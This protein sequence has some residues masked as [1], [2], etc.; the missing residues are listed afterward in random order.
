[1][2]YSRLSPTVIQKER[3]LRQQLRGQ[4]YQPNY[5][6]ISG[7]RAP[8]LNRMLPLA[9]KRSVHQQGLAIDIWIWDVNGDGRSNRRD[10]EIC[11][12]TLDRID[13]QQKS[14]RGGLGTYYKSVGRMVHFD[15]A[16]RKRRWAE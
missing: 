7:Y 9:S 4:G 10:V 6:I 11:V 14:L 3:L 13:R 5:W 12:N 1:M 16:G 8:W 2:T 15:V